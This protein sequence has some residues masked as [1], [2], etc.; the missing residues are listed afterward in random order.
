MRR[1]ASILLLTLFCTVLPAQQMTREMIRLANDLYDAIN[2]GRQQEADVL[3]DRYLAFCT[4]DNLR[5]GPYYAEAKHVKA[6]T[7]AAKGDFRQAQQIMDEVIA[8]RTDKRATSNDDRLGDS[9]FDRGKYY[10]QQKIID[11]AIDDLQAA[12]AAYQKAKEHSKYA[13][14][15]CQTAV[16]YRYRK[17]PGDADLEVECYEK[18]F[19]CV[20]KGTLEY[21]SVASTMIKVY[22][23]QGKSAKASKLAKQM[24]KTGKKISENEPLRYAE[25]LLSA[26]VADA[27]LGQYEQ[28]LAYANEALAIYEEANQSSDHNYAVL[29]KNTGDCHYHL[30]NFQEALTYYEKAEP[31]LLQTEGESGS[32]YLGCKLQLNATNAKVG[33]DIGKV[34]DFLNDLENKVN[35]ATDKSTINYANS[36]FELAKGEAKLGNYEKAASWGELALEQ[37][38]TRGDSLLQANAH[39]ALSVY[40]ARLNKQELADKH[41]TL[42]LQISKRPGS[43]QTEANALNQHGLTLYDK[44]L[45]AEADS[46]FQQA[47]SQFQKS[48]RA[49]STDYANA[50]CN[51][52]LCQDKL[53]EYKTAISL[54]REA[55]DLKTSILGQE[56]GEN[57]MLLFN[58]AMYYHRIGQM[59][60]VADYYHRAITLQTLQVRNNFSFQSTRQRELY[61]QGKSYLYQ[62]AP[63]LATTPDKTP[64]E[65]LTDIYNAQLFTKGILLNSE[66]DFRRLLQKSADKTVLAQYDELQEL[67]AELQQCYEAK[68]GEGQN[69]IPD[70]QRR[71]TQLE[72]A[73]VRQCKEYGDFTQNLSL[74]ADSV[75]RSLQPDEA[76]V[77]F[78]EAN[79]NY[80]GQ[81][82]R[83]YLALIL[84]P[85][86]EAPHACRLFFRSD[87]E[88]LG[89]PAN[90][91]VSQLLSKAEWQNKIY[92]DNKLGQL[93]WGELLANID[94]AK[95]IFFAPTGA[96]YQWGIEYMPVGNNGTRI[97]DTLSVSRLSS[98]KMLAQRSS[99]SKSLGNGEA[100]IYGGLE[101]EN[102][103]V[104]QMQAYH[105]MGDDEEIEDDEDFA[106]ELAAELEM[107]DSLAMLA[108]TERGDRVENL[109]ASKKEVDDIEMLLYNAG[110]DFTR[111]T[112][113]GGTEESFKRLSGQDISLLHVATHGFSYPI[114]ESSRHEW[115][116]SSAA[117]SSIPTDPLCYS[118]LLFSGCNNKMQNPQDFPTDI[119]DGILTAQEI[120]QLNLQNLQL[121]V[122]SACQTGTGMLQEDGVFGVQRGFKKAGAHT[123]V[124]SL[125]SVSD[126]ATMLMMTTFYKALLSGVPRHQAFLQAQAAVREVYPAPHYWAP[127]IMLDDI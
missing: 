100:V 108:M 117:S 59:D 95:H 88:A 8:A 81:P 77:E 52:A 106:A 127:F 27:N 103:S 75:R 40:Y 96:F 3:A 69:N 28:A 38:K 46:V 123:L 114:E 120:S 87:M 34:R 104:E 67:R 6:H 110:K 92:N 44:G 18:A 107:A 93:V 50:L 49:A 71:I 31:L 5:Y 42:A 9:Y 23:E 68:T 4:D 37:Y 53:K 63:L 22:N 54:T 85:Q 2:K 45:Y 90:V 74:T 1:L 51:R 91:P 36:L 97:S 57:V 72:Y 70:L 35:N 55:L 58:L 105:E 113:F 76:A 33:L 25:F 112:G 98:T 116:R 11:K 82:D 119:E 12:A 61:W 89:Y 24:Q 62:K 111:H 32:V 122:L 47:L 7:A 20:E 115:L 109:P 15:L 125:W 13:K 43:S 29:L 79:I 26:S 48:G 65:L 84:R 66:I 56:H 64:A 121:T 124:M 102:M 19:P 86:W 39:S 126:A 78:L 118:G 17:A 30:Q 21:L 101:Y 73:I 41:N 60:S 14:A 10:S 83:L 16:F 94:G 99:A 80:G